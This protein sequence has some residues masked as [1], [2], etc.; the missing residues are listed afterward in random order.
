MAFDAVYI[1]EEI[2]SYK[3]D[4]G[5]F[6]YLLEKVGEGLGEGKGIGKGEVLMTAHGLRSDHVPCAEMG[7][8]SAWIARGEGDG[9]TVK[10]VEGQV[11]FT[12]VF[13]TMGKLSSLLWRSVWGW[14]FVLI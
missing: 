11:G 8:A 13:D 5:N 7:I 4:L 3:P 1:A 14:T 10:E 2:G 6:R 12:W 9:E